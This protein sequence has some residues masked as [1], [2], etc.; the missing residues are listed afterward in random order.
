MQVWSK[1]PGPSTNIF[2]PLLPPTLPRGVCQQDYIQRDYQGTMQRG[3]GS[4]QKLGVRESPKEAIMGQSRR[5]G[6]PQAGA[7]VSGDHSLGREDL[8]WLL[9]GESEPQLWFEAIITTTSTYLSILSQYRRHSNS[10]HVTA[11]SEVGSATAGPMVLAE[12]SVQKLLASSVAGFCRP[13][14]RPEVMS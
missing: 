13:M 3:Y 6:S 11:A 14:C 4:R 9:G 8:A 1:L 12:L 2:P 10:V 7:V 5:T